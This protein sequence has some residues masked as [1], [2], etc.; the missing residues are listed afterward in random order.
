MIIIYEAQMWLVP[1]K[2]SLLYRSFFLDWEE[3]KDRKGPKHEE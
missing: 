2:L 1:V 3:R